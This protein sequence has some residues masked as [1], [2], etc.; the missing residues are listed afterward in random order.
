[1]KIELVLPTKL[2][3]T[4]NELLS[5]ITEQERCDIIEAGLIMSQDPSVPLTAFA[6]TINENEFMKLIVAMVL[7]MSDEAVETLVDILTYEVS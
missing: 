7:K 5:K 4:P 3:F 6:N 2:S 1:M